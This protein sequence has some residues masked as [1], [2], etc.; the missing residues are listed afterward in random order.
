M[1][2]ITCLLLVV[3]AGMSCSIFRTT[4][5]IITN[6]SDYT[7]VL[8]ITNLKKDG[9]HQG[10]EYTELPPRTSTNCKLYDD[11]EVI[12]TNPN[13]NFLKKHSNKS[14]EVLNSPKKIVTVFNKSGEKIFLIEANDLFDKIEM[15]PN[16]VKNIEVFTT[17]IF[18]PYAT[19][20]QKI[21][22]KISFQGNLLVITF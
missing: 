3:L 13:R 7:A 18:H 20:E 4:D 1:K 11:G 8:N 19:N 10:S 17:D 9:N 12:L 14:Y 22:L 6:N 5:V 16:E 21:A 15:L 2:K